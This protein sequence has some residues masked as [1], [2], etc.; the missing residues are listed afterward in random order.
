[1][2]ITS[3]Y[4]ILPPV[5]N[6]GHQSIFISVFPKSSSHPTSAPPSA[7]TIH[8]Y[9][10]ANYKAINQSLESIDWSSFFTSDPTSSCL[11]FH[12][13]IKNLFCAHI[14]S[15]SVA[16]S[17]LPTY[18]LPWLTPQIKKKIRHCRNLFPKA[19]KSN[20]PSIR[21][22]YKHLHNEIS[23]DLSISK[24][25]FMQS[26]SSSNSCRFWSYIKLTRKSTTSIPPLASSLKSERSPNQKTSCILLHLT[27]KMEKSES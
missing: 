2:S 15:K 18:T 10:K 1:M 16:P 11:T 5:S 19:K 14:P 13:T 12:D 17:S 9:S 21:S 25:S 22:A 4:M 26:L 8:L 7:K 23:H 27:L 20:S 6:S 3:S 24:A